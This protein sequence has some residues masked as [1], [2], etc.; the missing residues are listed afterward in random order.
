MAGAN[1]LRVRGALLALLA[2]PALGMARAPLAW[3]RAI[4]RSAVR[5]SSSEERRSVEIDAASLRDLSS[6]DDEEED[7]SLKGVD[8]YMTSLKTGG[9]PERERDLAPP[10]GWVPFSN[11]GDVVVGDVESDAYERYMMTLRRDSSVDPDAPVVLRGDQ[12]ID[13]WLGSL[14]TGGTPESERNMVPPDGY[15]PSMD[16]LAMSMGVR[17]EEI[18]AKAEREGDAHDIWMDSLRTGGTPE[19]ERD[20]EAPEGYMPY[21]YAPNMNK[22]YIT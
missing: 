17:G 10:A 11:R 5:L 20:M 19:N 16:R 4:A 14:K 15:I 21:V 6:W 8:S 9:T 12:A 3:P 18:Y 1:C 22:I 13:S 2:T 7:V